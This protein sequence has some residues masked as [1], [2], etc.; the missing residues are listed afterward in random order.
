M[1]QEDDDGADHGHDESRR[2]SRSVDADG[3][4]EEPSEKRSHDSQQ[5]GENASARVPPGREQLR[6]DTRHEPEGDP[7][8]HAIELHAGLSFRAS[9]GRANCGSRGGPPRRS[10]APLWGKLLSRDTT[11]GVP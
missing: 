11:D 7:C 8:E 6:D 10:S 1:N 2:F 9:R 4:A 5:H 3:A